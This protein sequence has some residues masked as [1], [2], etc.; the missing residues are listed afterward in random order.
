M[1][2]ADSRHAHLL[3]AAALLIA[4]LLAYWPAFSAGYIWDDPDHVHITDRLGDLEDLA[5]IWT[6]LGATP[7]YYPL[8]HTTFWVEYQLWGTWPAGYHLVNILLHG[9]AAVLFWRVLL[10]WLAAGACGETLRVGFGTHKPPYV[11]EGEPR[12][13]AYELVDRAAH[14]AGFQKDILIAQ[15][16]KEG[17]GVGVKGGQPAGSGI[18]MVAGSKMF[19]MGPAADH[20]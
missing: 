13:L 18:A 9:A 16:L 7:Q 3:V 11:F 2:R 4:T 17:Q 14:L 20:V 8:V 19:R 10:L 12:G 1:P 15:F 5:R 6:E